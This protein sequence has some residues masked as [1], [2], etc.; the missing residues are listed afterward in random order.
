[1][2]FQQG[3]VTIIKLFIYLIIFSSLFYIFYSI[4]RFFFPIVLDSEQESVLQAYVDPVTKFFEV[5][6]NYFVTDNYCSATIYQAA[7]KLRQ[8]IQFFNSNL[9]SI[10]ATGI[11][12]YI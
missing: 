9:I 10:D 6:H 4:S 8:Y 7:H 5:G 1:M 2:T 12:H 11:P 3:H